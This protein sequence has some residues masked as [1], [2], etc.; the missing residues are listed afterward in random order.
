[1]EFLHSVTDEGGALA[2]DLVSPSAAVLL[3]ASVLALAS[4]L[5]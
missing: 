4:L 1:M 2:F 3:L 5:Q